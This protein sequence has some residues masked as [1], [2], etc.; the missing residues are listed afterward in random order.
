M[1]V[2]IR[3]NVGKPSRSR[4]HEHHDDDQQT[5]GWAKTREPRD[6]KPATTLNTAGS[7]YGWAAKPSARS[8]PAFA[9][10]L[11]SSKKSS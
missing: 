11:G 10:G 3:V 4:D 1:P 7:V 5:A 9:P 6:E 8:G 2:H